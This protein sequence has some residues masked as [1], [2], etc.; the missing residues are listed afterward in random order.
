MNPKISIIIPVYNVEKYIEKCIKSVIN[1]TYKNIEIIIIIDGSK[2]NSANIVKKFVKKDNRIVLVEREN[3]GVM[4]TRIEGVQMATGDF[5]MFLD[6]DDWI[7]HEACLK[8]LDYQMKYDV[9]IVRCSY[10][11]AKRDKL[12]LYKTIENNSY[13]TKDKYIG[14]VY[15]K[16]I[17]KPNFNS[18]CFQLIKRELAIKIKNDENKITVAEDLNYNLDLYTKSQ[19]IMLINE[20]LYYYRVN[21][22]S[23]TRNLNYE[24]IK[25]HLFDIIYVYGKFYDYLE[26][27]N[28]NTEEN[29]K[30]VSLRLL[31]E[32]TGRTLDIYRLKKLNSKC[33]NDVLEMILNNEILDKI[34]ANIDKKNINNI[35]SN[36]KFVMKAIYDKKKWKINLYGKKILHSYK[37]IKSCKLF[38]K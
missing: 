22:E 20:G 15:N 9:D 14:M 2:D 27:W 26:I 5:I 7:D 8:L 18:M 36:K 3:R 19:S 30:K 28:I 35:Q 11:C 13:V 17:E 38:E 34:K 1:Q 32:I 12:Q 10:I 33:I 24:K 6:A 25:K 37:K 4:H 23:E 21:P 16:F 31:K 29:R